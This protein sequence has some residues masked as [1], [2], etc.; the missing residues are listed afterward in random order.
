MRDNERFSVKVPGST[1]N[2]GSGFDTVSAALNLYLTLD[3]E[4]VAGNEIQWIADW[5]LAPEENMIAVA[6]ADACQWLDINPGGLHI[7]VEN[8]IP[9]K[10][11][12]GS[13]A[14]AIVGG[15]KLAERLSGRN[16]GS[17]AVF[18]LAY[19]LEGHPENLSASLLGGWVISRVAEGNMRAERL[20]ASIDCQF[21]LVVPSVQVSTK[22]AREILPD[23]LSLSDAVFNLQRCALLIHAISSGKPGL[24]DEA[25][26]DR[27]HQSYRAGLVP[28][29]PSL[30]ERKDLPEDLSKAVLSVTVS[31]SGSTVLAITQGRCEEIGSWMVSTLERS[32]TSA[33]YR[34]LELDTAGARFV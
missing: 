29:V 10:R 24:L 25:T 27:L 23:D 28:G 8:A 11:G 4:R 7:R 6:L 16:L 30:L 31:G 13:S 9:L 19:P 22:N 34:V 17:D 18:E 21:V 33:H 32:G 15:I 5:E 1:S 3:V 20:S 26:G 12:L 2:L 14:A